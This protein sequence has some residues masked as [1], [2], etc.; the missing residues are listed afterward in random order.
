VDRILDSRNAVPTFRMGVTRSPFE[1]SRSTHE[2]GVRPWSRYQL[3]EPMVTEVQSSHNHNLAA[4]CSSSGGWSMSMRDLCVA[5]AASSWTA[6]EL[7]FLRRL[8]GL[9]LDARLASRALP[10]LKTI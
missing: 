6:D 5:S 1:K 9:F 7:R 10:R 2:M 8:K 4:A 3:S